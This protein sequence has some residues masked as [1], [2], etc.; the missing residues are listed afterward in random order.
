MRGGASWATSSPGRSP[1]CAPSTI[2]TRR[3]SGPSGSRPELL[4]AE[5]EEVLDLLAGV[6]DALFG[7]RHLGLGRA[8]VLDVSLLLVERL[9]L[10]PLALLLDLLPRLVEL[11]H[12]LVELG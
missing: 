5:R 9:G 12:R 4:H 2:T 7:L 8:A 11:L 10:G 3:R 6:A 1:T